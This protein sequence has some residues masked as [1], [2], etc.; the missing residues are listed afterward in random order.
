M[1]ES[2]NLFTSS[3]TFPNSISEKLDDS[4]FLLWRQQIDLVIKSHRLQCF[5]VNPVIPLQFLSDADREIGNE[6]PAYEIWEQHDQILLA[7]LQL[8]LSKSILL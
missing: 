7:W 6:N 4:N 8:T 1:T 5:V 2:H 3:S